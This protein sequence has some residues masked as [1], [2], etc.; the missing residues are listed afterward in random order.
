MRFQRGR[1]GPTQQVRERDRH[2]GRVV[3]VGQ[4][5]GEDEVEICVV[6]VLDV[7]QD[8]RGEVD[9]GGV[10]ERDESGGLCGGDRHD[11]YS[12]LGGRR[13]VPG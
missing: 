1:A 13:G 12:W 7:A 8:D 6:Q 2:V 9:D 11:G 5:V 10:L 4:L 3:G